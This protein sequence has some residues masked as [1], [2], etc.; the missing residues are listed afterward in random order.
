MPGPDAARRAFAARFLL[1]EIEKI[2]CK[3]YD[4]GV[5]IHHDEPAR[6]HDR[7]GS[8]QRF[9]VHREIEELLRQAAA[10]GSAGLDGFERLLQ[11][12]ANIKND[13]PQ[14]CAELHFNQALAADLPDQREGLCAAVSF[15]TEF[16]VPVGSV[17]Q[18]IR[19]RSQGLHIVYDG[20]AS[21]KA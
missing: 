14:R 3:V 11:S 5:F 6:P 2:L 20:R 17:S 7:P 12:A 13:L 19:Q 21:E 1:R 16:V 10:G 8:R 18:D 4:A 15:L 9:I